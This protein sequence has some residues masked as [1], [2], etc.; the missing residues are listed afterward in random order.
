MPSMPR[1]AR[2]D[3]LG[4][5]DEAGERA[6]QL[7][8]VR[9]ARHALGRTGDLG[10]LVRGALADEARDERAALAARDRGD[11]ESGEARRA[12][13]QCDLLVAE[14]H[15]PQSDDERHDRRHGGVARALREARQHGGGG[16]RIDCVVVDDGGEWLGHGACIG[17]FRQ[18]LYPLD[19]GTT[20]MGGCGARARRAAP[21]ARRARPNKRD[22]D[23]QRDGRARR[24]RPA[25]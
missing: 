18:D 22:S 9:G 12:G 11:E 21:R 8:A 15:E 4:D 16:V 5:E 6:G 24:A 7:V 3:A 10:D 14:Q 19:R 13:R 23:E 17:R 20:R 2:L 25:A 1:G